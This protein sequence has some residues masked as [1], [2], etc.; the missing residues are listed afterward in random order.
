M[1]PGDTKETVSLQRYYLGSGLVWV[2][3]QVSQSSES[4]G[5]HSPFAVT[6]GQHEP[7]Y[8]A[9]PGAFQGASPALMK[10]VMIYNYI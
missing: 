9:H 5:C 8:F 1:L 3:L 2:C 10:E 7:I 4:L 6:R